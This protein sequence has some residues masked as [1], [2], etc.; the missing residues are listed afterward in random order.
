MKKFKSVQAISI[1]LALSISGIG[2]AQADITGAVY[3]DNAGNPVVEMQQGG[4]IIQDG[5]TGE[6][7]PVAA[8]ESV[9]VL[10]GSD[11][12]EYLKTQGGETVGFWAGL[13]TVGKV[14]AV[15]L[16]LGGLALIADSL[17]D[18]S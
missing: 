15:A 13:S 4:V 14:V 12:P 9:T 1:G 8:G 5:A 3:I 7:Q 18:G 10:P 11:A 6:F 16:G 17:S 2:A